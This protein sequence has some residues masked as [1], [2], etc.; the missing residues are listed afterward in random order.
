MVEIDEIK[1][2]RV[3]VDQLRLSSRISA[4]I[5]SEALGLEN[6]L[7]RPDALTEEAIQL[8][9]ATH[10]VHVVRSEEKN[11]DVVG[12]HAVANLLQRL[13]G[14][15]RV[16]VLLWPNKRFAEPRLT[17]FL[18]YLFFGLQCGQQGT[19]LGLYDSLSPSERLRLSQELRTRTGLERLSG[20]S[21]KF[22]V[23]A[24]TIISAKD[25]QLSFEDV[26]GRDE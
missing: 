16:A 1:L 18:T 6:R 15:T 26:F 9:A 3:R 14:K 25:R 5:W 7:L 10:P 22:F 19:I 17:I 21:R 23:K 13:S 11:F 24:P 2:R 20:V 4:A 8:L 12:N